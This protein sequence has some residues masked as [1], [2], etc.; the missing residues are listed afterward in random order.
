MKKGAKIIVNFDNKINLTLGN[1]NS[2]IDKGKSLIGCK[3]YLI[4][5]NKRKE[6]QR[7]RK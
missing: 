3:I 6:E 4:I 1:L 2:I 5:K 7:T